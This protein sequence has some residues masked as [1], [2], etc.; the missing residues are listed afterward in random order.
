ML[1]V[2]MAVEVAEVM[3]T[4]VEAVVTTMVVLVTTKVVL[5]KVKVAMAMM[6]II[7]IIKAIIMI[8]RAMI[9]IIRLINSQLT[10]IVNSRPQFLMNILR[11]ILI[12]VV[13]LLKPQVYVLLKVPQVQGDVAIPITGLVMAVA[14]D[15][16]SH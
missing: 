2:D 6:V 12:W 5:I 7:M 3:A 9:M 4:K 10:I 13:E 1:V 11:I 8:I 15:T 16:P 14:G